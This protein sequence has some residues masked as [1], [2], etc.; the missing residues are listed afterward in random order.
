[1]YDLNFDFIYKNT[2]L[3]IFQINNT[4]LLKYEYIFIISVSNCSKLSNKFVSNILKILNISSKILFISC[5]IYNNH[6]NSI[7]ILI[8]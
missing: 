4:S 7:V 2:D 1:M 6:I 3:G 5:K 8:G